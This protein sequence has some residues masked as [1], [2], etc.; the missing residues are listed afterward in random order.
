MEAAA[1]YSIR[2]SFYMNLAKDTGWFQELPMELRKH[3]L[4]SISIN[5]T[6]YALAAKNFGKT[7]EKEAVLAATAFALAGCCLDD[8][9]DGNVLEERR[10]ALEKLNW[11]YCAHYFVMFG[12][13]KALHPVDILYEAI[14][15]FL[16]RKAEID[17]PSYDE[18][19]QYLKQAAFAEQCSGS[20]IDFSASEHAVRDKSVLF[21]VIGFL[22]ALYGKH[23]KTEEKVFFLIG[24]IF[25][26][27]DDLC[28]FE[29]D[30]R[31]GFVN[32]LFIQKDAI[33]DTTIIVNE[34]Q[35]LHNAMQQIK[36]L[37]GQ[38]FYEFI[39]F[40]L[41]LWTLE[42]PYIYQKFLAGDF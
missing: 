26:S 14:G 35:W 3:Y 19:I 5:C 33:P 34:L 37:I 11:E 9:L 31:A 27:I 12:R 1:G 36:G 41:Q 21:V 20:C 39:R 23:T 8:M 29:E 4:L 6:K 2:L 7:L 13:R 28:D 10:L 22:L 30:K 15:D 24:E 17:R 25:R 16:K 18:L 40:N 32:S 42:N 38:P